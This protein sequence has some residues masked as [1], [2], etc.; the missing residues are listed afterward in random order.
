MEYDKDKKGKCK[1][2]NKIN[3]GD[4]SFIL[5]KLREPFIV[6]CQTFLCNQIKQGDGLKWI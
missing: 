4:D 6:R 5:C 2:Q 1:H 3:V